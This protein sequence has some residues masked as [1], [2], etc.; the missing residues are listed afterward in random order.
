MNYTGVTVHQEKCYPDTTGDMGHHVARG[1]MSNMYEHYWGHVGH[2]GTCGKYIS[3]V[4]TSGVT[5]HHTEFEK[6]IVNKYWS[7]E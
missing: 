7:N 4:D 5:N 1:K 6:M 2:H 3:C